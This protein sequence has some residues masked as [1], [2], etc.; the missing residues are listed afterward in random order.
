MLE[1]RLG[2][3]LGRGTNFRPEGEAACCRPELADCCGVGPAPGVPP[4]AAAAAA[5][6]P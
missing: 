1:N 2:V 6:A 3:E 4:A 5:I